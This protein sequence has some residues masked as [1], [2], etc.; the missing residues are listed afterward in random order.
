MI[1]FPGLYWNISKYAGLDGSSTP[2]DYNS[3]ENYSLPSD[4]TNTGSLTA[5]QSYDLSPNNEYDQYPA[6]PATWTDNYLCLASDSS[7]PVADK[8]CI[9]WPE[10]ANPN[11]WRDNYLCGKPWMLN[12]TA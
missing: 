9:Q 8:A 4:Y 1:F 6:D 10:P 12:L 2:A 7:G 3:A 5:D 11:T